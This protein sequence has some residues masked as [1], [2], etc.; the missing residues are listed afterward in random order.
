MHETGYTTLFLDIGGVFL[1]NGWDHHMREKAAQKFN[2]DYGE[3]N[4]RHTL[5]FDTYEIG[6]ITLDEYLNRVVFY[7]PRSFSI[8][9]F[10]EF[11]FAQSRPYPEMIQLIRDIKVRY[12]LRTIAVNNEGRE[13]M[14]ERIK[15]FQLK[16]FIDFFVCSSF[17]G[18]RKPDEEIYRIALDLAQVEPK[19]VIYIDDRPLLIEIGHE[20]GFKAIQHKTFEQTYNILKELLAPTIGRI[21]S[22]VGTSS[23]TLR[24]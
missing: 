11:M 22:Y 1:T 20:L 19:E 2:L 14:L 18:L 13:L 23:D 24:Q 12:S 10:K 16:E 6:K 15:R 3:M 8:E 17:V 21:N 5:T 7:H 9:E 4:S